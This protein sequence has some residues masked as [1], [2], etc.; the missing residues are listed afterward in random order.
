M[1]TETLRHREYILSYHKIQ[2][3][4]KLLYA[5]STKFFV[6]LCSII[7]HPQGF[8]ATSKSLVTFVS[9]EILCSFVTLCLNN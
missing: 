8:V 4:A 2:R 6:R 1:N 9:K 3:A 7:K 5:K